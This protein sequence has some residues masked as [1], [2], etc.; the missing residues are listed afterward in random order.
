MTVFNT[1]GKEVARFLTHSQQLERVFL[2]K[3]GIYLIKADFGDKVMTKEVI[4]Q[5]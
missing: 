2:E 3:S 5:E 4:V 1:V